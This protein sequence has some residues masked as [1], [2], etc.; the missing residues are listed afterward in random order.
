LGY[1]TASG[2]T[3]D[4]TFTQRLQ[5]ATVATLAGGSDASGSDPAVAAKASVTFD[6]TAANIVKNT[7]LKPEAESRSSE[8]RIGARKY[9]DFDNGIS[10]F[11][12]FGLASMNYEIEGKY[13]KNG[14]QG[15]TG[16]TPARTA[17]AATLVDFSESASTIGF[18][19]EL[20]TLY[21]VSQ[22]FHVGGKL[23]LSSGSVDIE[24]PLTGKEESTQIG[25]M[26][27]SLFAGMS[28]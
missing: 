3:V 11:Y 28:F 27:Y 22:Q 2:N 13:A 26:Q 14:T 4:D 18:Y 8:L 15:V 20:A 23:A 1:F 19:G 6:G 5:G 24:N 17:A 21:K 25:G 7:V 10:I 12:G 9:K 16:V